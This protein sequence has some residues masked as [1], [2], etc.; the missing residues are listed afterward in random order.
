MGDLVCF[1]FYMVH[2]FCVDFVDHVTHL[3]VLSLYRLSIIILL[4]DSK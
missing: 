2:E 3:I 1:S 4:S